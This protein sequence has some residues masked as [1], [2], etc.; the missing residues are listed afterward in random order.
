MAQQV[1]IKRNAASAVPSSLA[2]GELAYAAV[3]N[4]LYIGNASGATTLLVDFNTAS[5]DITALQAA[6]AA[7]TS[8]MVKIADTDAS[9]FGFIIDEDTMVS[10]DATKVPTQ[11]SVKA[12]VDAAVTS[13][14][15]G[16]MKYKG[17][18]DAATSLPNIA[19]GTGLV[20]DT[21]I[22]SVAGTFLGEAVEIG[23]MILVNA[24]A[25]TT[26]SGFNVVQRNI[27]LALYSLKADK[28]VASGFA[29]LDA[30]TEVAELPAGAAAATADS[31]LKQDGTWSNVIDAG[32]F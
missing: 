31:L 14:V 29:S 22:V 25:A 11:Q 7:N 16:G 19:G 10:D 32:T 28:G 12:F 3:P 23:D 13:G 9:A 2:F 4:K 1:L 24:D 27:D 26:I 17:V 8:A 15:V 5:T 21:Y 6:V 18:F 30:N 20:G